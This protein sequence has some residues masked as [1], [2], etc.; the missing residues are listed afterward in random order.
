[1]AAICKMM[2]GAGSGTVTSLPAG[3]DCGSYCS[4]YFTK[5]C[6]VSLIAQADAGSI[7]LEWDVDCSDEVSCLL[8]MDADMSVSAHFELVTNITP[9]PHCQSFSDKIHELVLITT[10]IY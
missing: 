9:L 2:Q 4:F 8:S 3:I 6:S 5:N 10:V 7:F 1:M